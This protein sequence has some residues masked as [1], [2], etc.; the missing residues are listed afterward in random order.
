MWVFQDDV[1]ESLIRWSTDRA[2]EIDLTS[3]DHHLRY[4]TLHADFCAFFESKLEKFLADNGS[5][6]AALHDLLADATAANPDGEE[7]QVLSFL[8]ASTDY[9]VF[10]QMMRDVA[11]Q[12][13]AKRDAAGAE[14]KS[15]DA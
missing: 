1:F 5:D 9:D 2:R 3:D 15:A 13:A 12:E 14:A 7:A 10:M 11:A 4:T 6:A 8:L